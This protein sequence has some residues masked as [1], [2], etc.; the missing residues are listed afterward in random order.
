MKSASWLDGVRLTLVVKLLMSWER[1]TCPSST[2]ESVWRNGT[3]FLFLRKSSV[4]VDITPTMDSVR[5]VLSNKRSAGFLYRNATKHINDA[6]S[7]HRVILVVLWCATESLSVS[8]LSTGAMTVTTAVTAQTNPTS[9][10]MS[11]NTFPGSITSYGVNVLLCNR[12]L[13]LCDFNLK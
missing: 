13:C 9:T 6:F 3:I 2:R 4:P 5:Y 11:H 8:C 1:W 12:L 10:Q 7:P